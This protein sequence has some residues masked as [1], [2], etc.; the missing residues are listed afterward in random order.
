MSR[1]WKQELLAHLHQQRLI[2]QADALYLARHDRAPWFVVL[3][4]GLAA[5]L[6]ALLLIGGALAAFLGDSP[7]AAAVA[8]VL[9]LASA[10]WLL[11]R[12]GVF[13]GQLGLA[14][15]LAGQGMLVVAVGQL[16]LLQPWSH[17]PPALMA[18]VVAGGLLWVPAPGSHR[19]ICALIALTAGAAV[20]GLNPLLAGYGLM[21]AVAA[22]WIWL[23]RRRW[24]GSGLASLCRALGGAVTLLALLMPIMAH[25][26]WMDV[27]GL[28]DGERT[29]WLLRWL[30]PLGAGALLLGVVLYLTRRLQLSERLGAVI[31]VVAS[32]ALGLQ[33]PGLLVA[34][35]LWLVLFHA[36][37]RFW[38][39]L[40]G[41]AGLLYLGDFY[42]S[43]HINLLH[44]S[45]LLV[46]SGV[47]LLA[48]REY[49]LRHWRG[50][51]EK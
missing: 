9:L 24:A 10:I 33:A 14:L 25:R 39:V 41:V 27:A 42:Y 15:S 30:Y 8:G 23:Q 7:A 11:G 4:A 17:R 2:D 1:T 13:A 49:L 40:A 35:A 12:P 16:D 51:D 20:V 19:L 21:L 29:G 31:A 38:A 37:E 36:C 45:L 3:L 22:V 43:L 47:L 44:K 5:W 34:A 26:Y 50:Q 28:M 32:G 18:M 46:L 6:A 48:L